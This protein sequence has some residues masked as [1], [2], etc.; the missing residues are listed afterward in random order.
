MVMNN[1]KRLLIVICLTGFAFAANAQVLLT[2]S[3][4]PVD[5][6][7]KLIT[8]TEVVIQVGTKDSL[9]NRAI[10][11]TN[12]FY[13]NPQDVTKVR[14]KE[15]GKI[16]CKHRF[17]LYNYDKKDGS[18]IETG[19]LVQYTMNLAFKD[20]K[21]RYTITDF[22]LKGVSYYPLERWLN[23]QDPTYNANDENYLTQVDVYIKDMIKNLKK[24]MVPPVKRVDTW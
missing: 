21:F 15:N 10:G 11:W 22:N 4:V 6:V 12:K 14:D 13:A 24:A 18:K 17:K 8:Y 7:T 16:Q 1:F 5:S 19:M 20:G 2:P 3:I 23:K 9:Y